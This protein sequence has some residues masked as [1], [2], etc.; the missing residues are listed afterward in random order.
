MT[1]VVLLTQVVYICSSLLAVKT[2]DLS[3][4][5]KKIIVT[6]DKQIHKMTIIF[7]Q[8]DHFKWK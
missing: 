2:R 1:L 3:Q 5:Q 7:T 4:A 6:H 8:K